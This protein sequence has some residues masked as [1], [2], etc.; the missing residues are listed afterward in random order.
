M[1]YC[2]KS[3]SATSEAA[4]A[5]QPTQGNAV[6]FDV[7]QEATSTGGPFAGKTCS[8]IPQKEVLGPSISLPA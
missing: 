1:E 4:L 8:L 7:T 5:D 3:L 2:L 6:T